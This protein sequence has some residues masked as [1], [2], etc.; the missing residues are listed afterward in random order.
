MAKPGAAA[1][2][3]LRVARSVS[4]G[5]GL[6]RSRQD[7]LVQEA[8][9]RLMDRPEEGWEGVDPST[10]LS[11]YVRGCLRNVRREKERAGRR[12]ATVVQD[13][14]A[15]LDKSPG[16]A[17]EENPVSSGPDGSPGAPEGLPP[18]QRELLERILDGCT[19]GEAAAELG[20]S[21]GAAR[22]RKARMMGAVRRRRDREAAGADPRTGW[23][24]GE[25][26]RQRREAA[27][28]REWTRRA[29]A[30]GTG[31]LRPVDLDL[32]KRLS[33]GDFR[34]EIAA[35]LG[36]TTGGLDKRVRRLRKRCEGPS[37]DP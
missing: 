10:P 8:V 18:G 34:S 5:R 11:G 20:I 1:L 16:P 35:R 14:A 2:T 32:L 24:P 15:A 23:T 36:I 13:L 12:A 33:R 29:L 30:G 28:G 7:D 6:T 21:R 31:N 25:D 19:F 17:M 37:T 3:L 9:V 22:C 26:A 27:G 4:G